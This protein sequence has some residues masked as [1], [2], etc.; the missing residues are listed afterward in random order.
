MY[1]N[2]ASLFMHVEAAATVHFYVQEQGYFVWEH[3]DEAYEVDF[4]QVERFAPPTAP[5]SAV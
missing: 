5:Q 4:G 1:S 2:E 3:A